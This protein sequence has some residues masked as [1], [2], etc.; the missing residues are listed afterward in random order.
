[1][2]RPFRD[3]FLR[4]VFVSANPRKEFFRDGA[5]LLKLGSLPIFRILMDF[6][7]F[8]AFQKNPICFFWANPF[9]NICF[10]PCLPRLRKG[11]L[12]P[13]VVKKLHELIDRKS[14]D[15]NYT[16]AFNIWMESDEALAVRCMGQKEW[17]KPPFLY[18]SWAIFWGL[19]P[20]N[21]YQ[22]YFVFF[23]R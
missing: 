13:H 4:F 12:K 23:I 9:L 21:F 18:N 11:V 2:I 6:V 5:T 8:R 7:F 3:Y 19:V 17:N 22:S 15:F 1:M 20:V 14:V 10:G 16:T